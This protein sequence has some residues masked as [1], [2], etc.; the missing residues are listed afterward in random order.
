MLAI[1][2]F[3]GLNMPS[4]MVWDSYLT[5]SLSFGSLLSTDGLTYLLNSPLEILVEPSI[6]SYIAIGPIK[7]FIFSVL[8][9]VNERVSTD[10]ELGLVP[11]LT[12]NSIYFLPVC[13][14]VMIHS[15]RL[16]V[17]TGFWVGS[18]A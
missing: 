11:A 17:V 6:S 10:M 2:D 12:E 15:F 18:A 7:A 9:T 8:E 13:F 4:F 3:V 1:S 16:T 5:R 14:T